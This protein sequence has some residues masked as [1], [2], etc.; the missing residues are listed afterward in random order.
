MPVWTPKSCYIVDIDDYWYLY[1]HHYIFNRWNQNG[2]GRMMVENIKGAVAVTTT[3]HLLAEKI[4]RYNPNV[5]V[6]P[7]ALPFDQGQFVKKKTESKECRFFYAGGASHS[8]DLFIILDA[9]IKEDWKCD[10]TIQGYQKSNASWMGIHS[11]WSRHAKFIEN[12]PIDSY[13]NT[14]EADVMLIPLENNVFNQHK[15]NLK[16]LEAAAKGM[17]VIASKVHPY[18]NQLEMPYVLYADTPQEWV[19]HMAFCAAN[20]GFVKE[21]AAALREHCMKHYDLIK[22]NEIRRDIYSKYI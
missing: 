22:I 20:P 13:L 16:V 10:I 7:N 9:L 2:T 18:Y 11:M 1:P 5:Y 6:V 21:Q 19:G 4:V 3:N 8:H 17:A 12:K 15:S 14:Y